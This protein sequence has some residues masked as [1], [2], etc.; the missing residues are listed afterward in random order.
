MVVDRSGSMAA[1][2]K[3]DAV[4]TVIAE[5]VSDGHG[6]QGYGVQRLYLRRRQRGHRPVGRKQILRQPDHAGGERAL[7]PTARM[8]VTRARTRRASPGHPDA[9]S[10]ARP[11][12]T[13]TAT[14][15]TSSTPEGV[16]Q[17]LNAR[18]L[19]GIHRP[20]GGCG[21]PAR[22]QPSVSGAERTYLGL[23]PR[24]AAQRHSA[25]SAD[26]AGQRR[27]VHLRRPRPAWQCRGYRARPTEPHGRGR[28]LER[29]CQQRLHLSL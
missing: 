9:S 28:P 16:R 2:G 3:I 13:P 21:S 20:A 19:R 5:Q 22:P 12:S 15:P 1:E 26:R 11:G 7:R 10:T 14:A 6:P 18:G 23:R 8:P 4:K 25:L 24:L 29:L 17:A 27:P